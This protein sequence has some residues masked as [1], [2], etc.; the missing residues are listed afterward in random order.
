MGSY[1]NWLNLE[2]IIKL[3]G[4]PGEYV[5]RSGESIYAQGIRTCVYQEEFRDPEYEE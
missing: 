3:S 2:L 5:K 4:M 1:G